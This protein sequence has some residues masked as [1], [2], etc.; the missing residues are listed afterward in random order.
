MQKIDVQHSLKFHQKI[1]FQNIRQIFKIDFL[2][3]VENPRQLDF[4][5]S[6]LTKMQK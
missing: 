2:R 6:N 4:K 1:Q 3:I 5:I